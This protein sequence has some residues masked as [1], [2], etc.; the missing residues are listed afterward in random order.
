ME[1]DKYMAMNHDM[2][3]NHP[4]IPLSM[5]RLI[6]SYREVGAEAIEVVVTLAKVVFVLQGQLN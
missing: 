2:V 3:H 4:M 1:Y 5:R 6:T